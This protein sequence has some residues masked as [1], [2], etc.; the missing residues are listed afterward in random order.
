[1]SSFTTPLEIQLALGLGRATSADAR[2]ERSKR[3]GCGA[4]KTA[5]TTFAW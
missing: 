5:D 4:A 3:L 2:I 1:M